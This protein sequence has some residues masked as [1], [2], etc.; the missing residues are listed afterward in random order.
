MMSHR[1]GRF[2]QP[3][4]S[5]TRYGQWSIL[6][7]VFTAVATYAPRSAAAHGSKVFG[8]R[9]VVSAPSGQAGAA[10]APLLVPLS[11]GA[12]VRPAPDAPFAWL[13]PD[14]LL[15][16]SADLAAAAV[17]GAG[18]LLVGDGNAG[19]L[20]SDDWGCSWRATGQ[21]AG[22]DTFAAVALSPTAPD[23][24]FVA[25]NAVT[26]GHGS[27]WTTV[28][29]GAHYR[30]LGF[31]APQV[32]LTDLAASGDTL[33]AGGTNNRSVDSAQIY[34]SRDNGKTWSGG[35]L[36]GAPATTS[37]VRVFS[38]GA[39][40]VAAAALDVTTNGA[41]VLLAPRPEGPWRAAWTMGQ[42]VRQ[43]VADA[44][45]HTVLV[46][47][48][49][50]VAISR[51]AG[52]NFHVPTTPSGNGCAAATPEGLWACGEPA[53]PGGLPGSARE[54]FALATLNPSSDTWA[55]RLNYGQLVAPHHCA[56]SSPTYGLCMPAWPEA[57]QRF[58]ARAARPA[59]LPKLAR[60]IT[61]A[62]AASGCV[63]ARRG[64]TEPW[65][66]CGMGQLL[67]A[68]TTC[69][70]LRPPHRRAWL[71]AKLRRPVTARRRQRRRRN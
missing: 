71:W 11:S 47:G 20:M 22:R 42:P 61:H 66:Q 39:A 54:G 30:R 21:F 3:E 13:C 19:L 70:V 50:R 51:D 4:K 68:L 37:E 28:D 57:A 38:L 43:V 16:P 41:T 60:P 31:S 10:N 34:F 69:W 62:A 12:L 29:G 53:A 44:S 5:Y 40:G 48:T 67:A 36:H 14:A 63:A 35:P 8:T 27:V 25:S 49:T 24:W 52:R 65:W 45:G 18:S 46:G 15:G 9:G 17:T 59:T 1:P 58:G 2:P 56:E 32:Y 6:L 23:T 26:D 7:G 33:L 55:P 64:A